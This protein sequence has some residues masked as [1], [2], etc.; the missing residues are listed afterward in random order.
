MIKSE[1]VLEELKGYITQLLEI[2]EKSHSFWLLAETYLLQA[3][4]ALISLDV[5][6]ARKLLS[7]AQSIAEKYSLNQ[8]V[9]KISNE[10]DKLLKQLELWEKLKE[11]QAPLT[12]RIQ[13]SQLN[14]QM[15]LIAKNRRPLDQKSEVEQPVWLAILTNKGKLVMSN[16]FYSDMNLDDQRLSNFLSSFNT[17]CDQIFSESFDRVKFGQ[18]T[19]LI[20]SVDSYYICYMFQGQTYNARQKLFHF[21]D[22]I[23]KDI[24][25]QKILKEAY[26]ENLLIGISEFPY[27]EKLIQE[28]FLSSPKGFKMPFKAYTGDEPYL[29]VSYAHVNRLLV[30][31]IIDK[32]HKIGFNIWYDEGIPISQNWKQSIV[33]H[34]ERSS[35]FLLFVTP[36]IIESENVR[37]EISF[38]LKKEKSFIIVYLKETNLPNEL[39]FE[40]ADIQAIMKYLMSDKEFYEKLNHTITNILS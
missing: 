33:K 31:P 34:L 2:A 5:D 23:T 28:S 20:K 21:S 27:L 14:E 16:P 11:T 9:I 15:E 12:E 36:H 17:F 13:L 39:M 25:L 30:Y 38:A 35:A 37:K 4:I 26:K 29:F 22:L 10:H 19:V 1:E 7:K 18:F 8:L 32:L 40:I 6:E 3:K 24:E